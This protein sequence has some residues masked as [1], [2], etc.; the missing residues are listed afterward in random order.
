MA[1]QPHRR[2]DRTVDEES[3]GVEETAA[4]RAKLFD[5]LIRHRVA[6][7][8][9]D[10]IAKLQGNVGEAVDVDHLDRPT[11]HS[12]EKTFDQVHNVLFIYLCFYAFS[13]LTCNLISS[14]LVLN[15]CHLHSFV[16]IRNIWLTATAAFIHCVY[17]C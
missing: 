9:Q 2:S 15:Q 7:D 6:G 4:V 17:V 8:D 13:C 16:L 3:A 10:C 11:F 12:R 1:D 5:L 14:A